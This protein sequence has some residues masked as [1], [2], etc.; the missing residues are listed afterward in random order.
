MEG[1]KEPDEAERL[2][3]RRRLF[4]VMAE[5]TGLKEELEMVPLRYQLELRL[6]RALSEG[7]SWRSKRSSRASAS[8]GSQGRRAARANVPRCLAR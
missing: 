3:R 6:D 4:Q 2:R 5:S 8:N 7:D 1:L